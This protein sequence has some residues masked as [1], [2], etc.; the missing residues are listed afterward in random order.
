MTEQVDRIEIE[1]LVLPREHRQGKLILV[2]CPLDE[3]GEPRYDQRSYFNAPKSFYSVGW[4]CKSEGTLDP[5]NGGIQS[6]VCNHINPIK[7][8]DKDYV[9]IKLQDEAAK[10]AA[11]LHKKA[12]KSTLDLID[13]AIAPIA[14]AMLKTNH[15]GRTALLTLTIQRLMRKGGM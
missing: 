13:E 2:V 7:P 4:I 9:Q 8:F 12:K 5:D 3:Q 11:T 1:F 10:Q 14:E 6:L 15:Q